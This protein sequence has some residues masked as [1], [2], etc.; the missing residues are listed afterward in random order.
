MEFTAYAGLTIKKFHMKKISLLSLLLTALFFT[1]LVAQTHNTL[2]NQEKKAGWV[3]L[4]T[5]KALTDG[6]NTMEL[7]C[8]PNG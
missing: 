6:V 8:L 3:L 2:S 4:L 1:P 7:K 5:V